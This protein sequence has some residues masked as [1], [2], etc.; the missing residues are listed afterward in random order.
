LAIPS[1]RLWYDSQNELLQHNGAGGRIRQEPCP[2]RRPSGTGQRNF[3]WSILF[4]IYSIQYDTTSILSYPVKR[5][6]GAED[7]HAAPADGSWCSPPSAGRHAESASKRWHL[8][9]S[10][11]MQANDEGGGTDDALDNHFLNADDGADHD[12]TDDSGH[13]GMRAPLAVILLSLATCTLRI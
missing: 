1:K 2:S 13:F 5:V 6:L 4:S 8:T 7:F 9:V 11:A 3:M 12:A 10:H